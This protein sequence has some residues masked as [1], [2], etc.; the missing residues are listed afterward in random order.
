MAM[1]VK[2]AMMMIQMTGIIDIF[3]AGRIN[4]GDSSADKKINNNRRQQQPDQ[5]LNIFYAIS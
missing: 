1:G 3:F 4:I 5:Y 2:I